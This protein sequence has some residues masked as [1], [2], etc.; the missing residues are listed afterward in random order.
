MTPKN[1]KRRLERF[2]A[3]QLIALCRDLDDDELMEQ[4]Q[5]QYQ[6]REYLKRTTPNLFKRANK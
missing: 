3:L 2:Y 4:T 5:L 1:R 6:I